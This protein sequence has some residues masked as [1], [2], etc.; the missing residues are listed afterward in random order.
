MN[1]CTRTFFTLVYLYIYIYGKV[2][3]NYYRPWLN[4]FFSYS[5]SIVRWGLKKVTIII[6]TKFSIHSSHHWELQSLWCS[7]KLNE[8]KNYGTNFLPILL[9]FSS[10][11]HLTIQNFTERRKYFQICKKLIENN[12]FM[13]I[14]QNFFCY[15][16]KYS[17]PNGSNNFMIKLIFLSSFFISII[18]CFLKKMSKPRSKLWFFQ[19]VILGQVR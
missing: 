5:Q 3:S 15:N 10:N 6:T 11:F 7:N 18:Y 1:R 17:Y 8:M 4:R 14:G 19:S 13:K 16:I 2:E 9:Y 12:F